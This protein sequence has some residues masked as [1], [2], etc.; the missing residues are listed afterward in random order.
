M[1]DILHVEGS[2]MQGNMEFLHCHS[3][4]IGKISFNDSLLKHNSLK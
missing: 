2:F 1:V 3:N 4:H